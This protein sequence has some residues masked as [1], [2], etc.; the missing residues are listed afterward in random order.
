MQLAMMRDP[1]TA[2]PYFWASFV[3]SGNP[4]TLDGA[5][6]PLPR[7]GRGARGCG[8]AATTPDSTATLALV[9]LLAIRRRRARMLS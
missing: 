5:S 3:V 2:H 8:C 7:F 6:A 4:D 1:K 9:V